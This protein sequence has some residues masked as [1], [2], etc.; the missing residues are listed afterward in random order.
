MKFKYLA[1]ILWPVILTACQADMTRN[2]Q[3]AAVTM[4]PQQQPAQT[5]TAYEWS[6]QLPGTEQPLILHFDE[7]HLSMT[8]GCNNQGTSW[9]IEQ[10]RIVT[11]ELTSTM[12]ACSPAR[13]KQEQL[14][15]AI[16]L[17]GSVPFVLDSTHTGHPVLTLTDAQGQT[18]AFKGNM[19]PETR[20]QSQAEIIFLEISP[21]T[22]SCTGVAPQTCLQVREIKYD[23]KG[24]KTQIDKDWTLFYDQIQGYIHRPDQRRIIRVK[25]YELK[26][27]AADQS[28]YAYVYDMTIEQ[29]MVQ[30]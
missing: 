22:R 24:T 23:G 26:N 30:P 8:T 15:S 28:K 29:E 21:E 25:R 27:P 10:N 7:Q 17:K 16:F 12:M 5:L 18:Y 4:P 11:T 13:M 9:K 1:T 14:S 3:D 2:I 19:T 20:Y 6:Y